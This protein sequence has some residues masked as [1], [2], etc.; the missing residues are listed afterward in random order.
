MFLFQP[1]HKELINAIYKKPDANQL[2]VLI[3]HIY[4]KR[5]RLTKIV[6]VLH[7]KMRHKNNVKITCNILIAI[8]KEFPNES[9]LYEEFVLLSVLRAMKKCEDNVIVNVMEEIKTLGIKSFKGEYILT[10]L[11]KEI[12]K[13]ME[14]AHKTEM[15]KSDSA[16]SKSDKQVNNAKKE[17]ET[18]D[19]NLKNNKH[20]DKNNKYSDKNNK[21]GDKNNKHSDKNN[22]YGDK[23]NK[24]SDKNNN[25][26]D[27]YNIDKR[28]K[29]TDTTDSF[30]NNHK[31]D[32]NLNDEKHGEG[33]SSETDVMFTN[34]RDNFLLDLLKTI[35]EMNFLNFEFTEKMNYLM[36][37]LTLSK[38]LQKARNIFVN[39]CRA[40]NIVNVKSFCYE[41]FWYAT[42]R[43]FCGMDLIFENVDNELLSF[44]IIEGNRFLGE[45]SEELR[46]M[47]EIEI[48]A[49]DK[50]RQKREFND[51]YMTASNVEVSNADQISADESK[52]TNNE[53]KIDGQYTMQNSITYDIKNRPVH[54]IDNSIKKDIDINKKDIE[55]ENNIK[56]I[57]GTYEYIAKKDEESAKVKDE[58]KSL[59]ELANK[60]KTENEKEDE[61]IEK[62]QEE[63][64]DGKTQDE[65]NERINELNINNQTKLVIEQI[66]NKKKYINVEKSAK[67]GNGA[68]QKKV[69]SPQNN[70]I[71]FFGAEIFTE[72]LNKYAHRKT[73]VALQWLYTPISISKIAS[74]H[75]I[76][77]GQSFFYLFKQ[78]FNKYKKFNKDDIINVEMN[79]YC[80]IGFLNQKYTDNDFLVSHDEKDLFILKYLHIFIKNCDY[81][82]DVLYLFVKKSFQEQLI[83]KPTQYT[84]CFQKYML[85]IVGKYAIEGRCKFNCKFFI[86]LI[87]VSATVPLHKDICYWLIDKGCDYYEAELEEIKTIL[88]KLRV[89]YNTTNNRFLYR[90]LVKLID[91]ELKETLAVIYATDKNKCKALMQEINEPN[92]FDEVANLTYSKAKDEA[93]FNELCGNT[94][95]YTL[96]VKSSLNLRTFSD[97]RKSRISGLEFFKFI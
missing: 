32:D 33:S 67:N 44:L 78:I 54:K 79:V 12:S 96:S 6:E 70:E 73:M 3:N 30:E 80:N 43:K 39:M 74:R 92:I 89:M 31:F 93:R 46:Q 91:F 22:N 40:L 66:Q 27:K 60:M 20:S 36:N 81:T 48:V 85:F 13:A 97:N 21:Y 51:E 65:I 35:S 52:K 94:N 72:S 23:N 63:K 8:M 62:E 86:L 16:S 49:R 47:L 69:T 41:F 87:R 38:N 14:S 77:I 68:V 84:E 4:L 83:N 19:T 58:Q 18:K 75:S 88:G 5:T 2:S 61:M 24:H 56:N 45:N 26:G 57:I 17:E 11:I 9:L 29:N 90:A 37:T 55:A 28:V 82:A 95:M 15:N 64:R 34:D 53:Q 25:Y 71:K 1:K 76:E 7:T 59:K 10:K 50:E 42:H